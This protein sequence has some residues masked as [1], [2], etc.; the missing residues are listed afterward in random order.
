MARPKAKRQG[1]R[2]NVWIHP[3]HLQLWQDIENKSGFVNLSL[4]EAIGIMEFA[5]LKKMNP[6]KYHIDR[7]PAEQIVPKFNEEFPLDELTAK[8]L[9]KTKEKQTWPSNSQSVP[10]LW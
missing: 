2:V 6:E 7:P 4:D 9:G 10:E 1:I 3:R 8:R 5:I